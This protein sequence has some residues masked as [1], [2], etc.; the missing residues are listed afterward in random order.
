MRDRIAHDEEEFAIRSNGGD[1]L[2][3]WYPATSVPSGTPH[4]ANGFCI[5]F[6]LKVRRCIPSESREPQEYRLDPHQAKTIHSFLTLEKA[7]GLF[8]W[9]G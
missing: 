3:A 9:S 8:H 1:W 2:I 5:T 4:G 6:E 7:G